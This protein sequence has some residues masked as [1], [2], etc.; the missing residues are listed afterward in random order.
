MKKETTKVESK[1]KGV[2]QDWFI[3]KLG[4]TVKATSL[5]EAVR[6]ANKKLEK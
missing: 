4:M 1:A 3:P 6:K 5:E 2:E